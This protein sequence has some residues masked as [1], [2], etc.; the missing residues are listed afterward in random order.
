MFAVDSYSS[1]DVPGIPFHYGPSN[2]GKGPILRM[3]DHRSISTPRLTQWV[4]ELAR[5][6][7]IPIQF[8]PTG[9]YTDGQHFIS[10]GIPMAMICVPVRYMHSPA[11]MV[12]ARDLEGL[13]K[14]ILAIIR[15]DK[16]TLPQ[17]KQA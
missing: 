16:E 11:E 12:H 13:F 7:N 2:L 3:M 6:E 15:A 17:F 8:G 14:L 1:A 4:L 10:R 9:G 5:K